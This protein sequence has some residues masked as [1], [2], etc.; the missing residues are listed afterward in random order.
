MSDYIGLNYIDY[1]SLFLS[2]GYVKKKCIVYFYTIT[3]FYIN[4]LLIVIKYI[5]DT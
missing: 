5:S 3:S 4:F 1:I 2:I